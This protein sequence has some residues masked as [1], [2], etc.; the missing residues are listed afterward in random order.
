MKWILDFKSFGKSNLTKSTHSSALEIFSRSSGVARRSHAA[1]VGCIQT[2]E[3]VGL[4]VA[5]NPE[6]A[7]QTLHPE[8]P[9]PWLASRMWISF[10][11][12]LRN[13]ANTGFCGLGHWKVIS[14][15]NEWNQRSVSMS[16]SNSS[17]TNHGTETHPVIRL[18]S[19]LLDAFSEHQWARCCSCPDFAPLD[20]AG[21]NFIFISSE[22]TSFIRIINSLHQGHLEAAHFQHL[23]VHALCWASDSSFMACCRV[24][25]S[26]QVSGKAPCLN[27]FLPVG[28]MHNC[29]YGYQWPSKAFG[30]AFCSTMDESQKSTLHST[31]YASQIITKLH[32]KIR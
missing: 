24:G 23:L 1:T 29:R 10:E 31:Q 25:L 15:G 6:Y 32:C 17:P 4:Q 13:L 7:P 22:A 30:K 21:M 26:S 9:R 19:S 3:E 5:P 14:F 20:L 18:Q 8:L 2:K 28:M 12:L 11:Q 16:G 27:I